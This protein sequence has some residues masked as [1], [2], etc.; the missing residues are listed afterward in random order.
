MC[1]ANE[2]NEHEKRKVAEKY[3]QLQIELIKREIEH[4]EREFKAEEEEKLKQIE[5]K[6]CENEFKERQKG[7]IF[8]ETRADNSD[9]V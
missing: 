9:G 6:E 1:E 7:N 8:G 2:R 3:E 4:K 5:L